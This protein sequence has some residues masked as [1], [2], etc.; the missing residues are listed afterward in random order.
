MARLLPTLPPERQQRLGHDPPAVRL[1]TSV[2]PT[3]LKIA[4]IGA[5][6]LWIVTVTRVHR[7]ECRQHGVGDVAGGGFDQPET[8][9]AEDLAR[10]FDDLVV[11]HRVHDLV[12]MR[13][14]GEINREFEIDGEAL[15]DLGLVGHHAVIGVQRQPLDEDAVGHRAAPI[16]AATRSACTVSLTSWTRT[17]A[18][19]FS[20]AMR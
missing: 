19:P 12:R 13:G 7:R 17:M 9:R 11:G 15:P 8:L 1:R 2:T 14:G 4:A 18:A 16:A 6:G 10:A 5:C 3:S 20:T